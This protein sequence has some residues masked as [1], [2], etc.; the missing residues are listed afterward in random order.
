MALYRE[1]PHCGAHLD[2]CE[3]CDCR[4]EKNSLSRNEDVKA[5]AREVKEKAVKAYA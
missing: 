1:C 2:C 4:D 5:S 3:K